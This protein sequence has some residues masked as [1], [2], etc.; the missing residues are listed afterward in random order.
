ML[1]MLKMQVNTCSLRAK[2][3]SS[4]ALPEVEFAAAEAP[5]EAV[6]EEEP[7]WSGDA[8]E[9]RRCWGEVPCWLGNSGFTCNPSEQ[10][11]V[12][13]IS[14]QS[15]VQVNPQNSMLVTKPVT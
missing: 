7:P 12:P 10:R 4:A 5:G 2:A 1:K 14:H 3:S 8:L 15:Q 9:G 13:L 6:E 11:P